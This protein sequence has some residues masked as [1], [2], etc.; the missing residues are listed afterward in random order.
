MIILWMHSTVY[1]HKCLFHF[2]L[3]CY[4]EESTTANGTLQPLSS[5][6][7]PRSCSFYINGPIDQQIQFSCSAIN[8]T[9]FDSY[10]AVIISQFNKIESCYFFVFFFVYFL[11]WQKSPFQ[12]AFVFRSTEWSILHLIIPLVRQWTGCIIRGIQWRT[13]LGRTRWIKLKSIL[14]SVTKTGSL[15]IGRR[16]R[17]KI[18]QIIKVMTPK[19]Q[20]IHLFIVFCNIIREYN[21]QC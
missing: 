2:F 4:Q 9:S 11:L 18:R 6:D 12:F 10:F 7:S 21:S 8:L 17:K 14:D 16:R 13:T 15:A 20:L 5:R 19:T 1:N 3:V